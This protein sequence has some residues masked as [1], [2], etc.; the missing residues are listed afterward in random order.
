[1]NDTLPMG[2]RAPCG[3]PGLGVMIN[4]NCVSGLLWPGASPA[5]ETVNVGV[6]WGVETQILKGERR[7]KMNV[8]L[9]LCVKS[10]YYK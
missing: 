9:R 8:H 10:I 6:F 3:L 5:V 2:T 1:M 4:G 7:I